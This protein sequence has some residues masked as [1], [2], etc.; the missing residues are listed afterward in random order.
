[1]NE[2]VE[3]FLTEGC[4]R[5]RLYRTPECKVHTWQAELRALR[6]IV[7][8]AGLTE[9]LKWKQPTYTLDGKNVVMV[10]A[11]KDTSFITFF[12]GA[13]MSD[14]AGILESPGENSQSAKY[15]RFTD[16]ARIR[17]LS[18][19]LSAYLIEAMEITRSGREA[20]KVDIQDRTI[21]EELQVR[22]DTL[23]ELKGAFEALTAGRR[24]F[25][26]MHF[27]QPKQSKTRADR[28]ER[29]I[30][31]ILAGKGFGED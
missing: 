24:R 6:E 28:V 14:P 30:P 18:K 7:L 11:F 10:S 29:C 25:Y 13:I 9:E 12:R 27:S 1:M 23:P 2:Q 4:G 16:V 8:A 3:L 26:L 17:A 5:C 20:P 15:V 21:P 31:S 19:T 22:F